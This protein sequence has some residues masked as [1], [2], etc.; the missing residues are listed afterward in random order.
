[1][2]QVAIVLRLGVKELYS[3][4]RDPVLMILILYSFTF[5]IYTVAQGVQTEV[6]NAA[7]AV[8]DEDRSVVSNR[9]RGAFQPPQF[10]PAALIGIGEIDAVLDG[11]HYSFV[12]DIPP[13]FQADLLAG[14]YPEIQLNVDATAM[15]LAGNGAAYIQNIVQQELLDFATRSG[16]GPT[17]P[18]TLVVRAFF[19]PNLDSTWFM[20]VMQ[21][22]NNVTI[23]A[24]I[25]SGAAVIREREH[26]TL[27]HLLVMPVTPAEIMLAKVWANGLVILLAAVLSLYAVVQGLLDVPIAGSIGLFAVGSALYLFAV[28]ALGIMLSTIAT[29]MPQFGLLSIPVFVVL[30]LLSGGSTPLES[31]PE[32][33]QTVMQFAP[34]AHFIKFAQAVLYRGAD[35]SV[36]WPSLLAVGAIG[37]VFFAAALLRFRATMAAAQ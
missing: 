11:G 31:M 23:M 9:I 28:T 34:T 22:V 7:I 27:E 8:V 30:N 15:T 10:Q 26:G 3:V 36:V 19:N 33:L 16:G 4:A 13:D 12:L 25:L 17:P 18:V 32:T 2:D 1:M 29:T 24:V 35:L 37:A 20:A 14:R 6:H 5:A 21:I